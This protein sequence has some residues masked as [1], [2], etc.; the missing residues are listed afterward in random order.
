MCIV[1]RP[2]RIEIEPIGQIFLQDQ[3]FR[4]L[5]PNLLQHPLSLSNHHLFVRE[6]F[7]F[8]AAVCRKKRQKEREK[9]RNGLK[10]FSG[11]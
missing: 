3:M 10:R 1:R 2:F 4:V 7:R 5:N 6:T 8:A 9:E 11:G